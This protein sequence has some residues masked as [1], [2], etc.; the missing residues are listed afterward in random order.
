VPVPSARII[1]RS[2]LD[3]L[4]L[5]AFPE[6][7]KRR[8]GSLTRKRRGAKKKMARL[9]G[10]LKV[11]RW[12]GVF[13]IRLFSRFIVSLQT[14]DVKFLRETH[15]RS[16]ASHCLHP[17]P[18]PWENFPKPVREFSVCGLT[19]WRDLSADAVLFLVLDQ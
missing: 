16:S 13:S 7:A 4:D 17:S 9:K 15:A 14:E 5:L 19:K 8:A 11:L 3:F 10:F 18:R 6:K 12:N 2:Y 1:R